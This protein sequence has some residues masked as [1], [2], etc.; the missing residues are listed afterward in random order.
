MYPPQQRDPDDGAVLRHGYGFT[1]P[2]GIT[3]HQQSP[4]EEFLV[5]L[6]RAAGLTLLLRPCLN[7]DSHSSKLTLHPLGNQK[8]RAK[9]WR[10][11]L[12]FASVKHKH[13]ASRG[14]T[15]W[16]SVKSTRY[17]CSS[18]TAGRTNWLTFVVDTS[19]ANNLQ[20]DSWGTRYRTC[21]SWG[22]PC[23][24]QKVFRGL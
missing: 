16:L 6:L 22:R 15:P 17:L 8:F 12:E 11:A 9:I 13:R 4:S 18:G 20:K 5:R 7:S 24:I 14:S 21:R 1:S 23:K 3:Q 10:R 2:R 19:L